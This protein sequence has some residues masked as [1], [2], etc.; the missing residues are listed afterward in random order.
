MSKTL[1]VIRAF[2]NMTRDMTKSYKPVAHYN[3]QLTYGHPQL[4]DIRFESPNSSG[5]SG[6]TTRA[7]V[8]HLFSS[9]LCE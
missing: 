6:V 3:T 1:V 5:N 9:D 4:T 7:G 8:C 2:P